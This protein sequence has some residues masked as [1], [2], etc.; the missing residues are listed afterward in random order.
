MESSPNHLENPFF[1]K[2]S[3]FQNISHKSHLGMHSIL[4]RVPESDCVLSVTLQALGGIFVD[5]SV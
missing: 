5:R 4:H 3:L 1:E 2:S